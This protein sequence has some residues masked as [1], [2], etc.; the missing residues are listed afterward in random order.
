MKINVPIDYLRGYLRYG[1]LEGEVN[2][3]SEEEKEF[4]TLLAKELEYEITKKEEEKLEEYKELIMENCEIVVDD[5]DIEDYGEFEWSEI[6][7]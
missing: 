5:Y 6:I 2:M 1:H 7:L 3:S 4:K